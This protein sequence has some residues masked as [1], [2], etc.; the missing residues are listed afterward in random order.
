MGKII[1]SFFIVTYCSVSILVMGKIEIIENK[2]PTVYGVDKT[3]VCFTRPTP[4]LSS[5][6]TVEGSMKMSTPLKLISVTVAS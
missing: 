3:E 1:D 4:I 2:L 5:P 6:F